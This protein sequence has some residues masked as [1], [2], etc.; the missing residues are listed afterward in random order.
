MKLWMVVVGIMAMCLVGVLFVS[1]GA[2][3]LKTDTPPAVVT[4]A[5]PVASQ[6]NRGVEVMPLEVNE[7]NGMSILDKLH[8][9]YEL[10][11]HGHTPDNIWLRGDEPTE[12]YEAKIRVW[13]GQVRSVM[14]EYAGLEAATTRVAEHFMDFRVC[15]LVQGGAMAFLI[16]R[17]ENPVHYMQEAEGA[18]RVCVIPQ[19]SWDSRMPSKFM[20]DTNTHTAYILA[21][22]VPRK[23]LASTIFHEF[24]HGVLHKIDHLPDYPP[25][26][27]MGVAEEV[28]MHEMQNRILNKASGGKLFELFEAI[29]QRT[30]DK[31]GNNNYLMAAVTREDLLAYDNMLQLEGMG[32]TVAKSAGT[33]FWLGLAFYNIDQSLHHPQRQRNLTKLWF[34]RQIRGWKYDGAE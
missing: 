29:G 9:W 23:L 24:G 32:S 5:V 26:S 1:R 3:S 15:H 21:I 34:Y 18:A 11:L 2:L 10:E 30:G 33:L 16:P 4:Q 31:R 17:G 27:D 13:A 12:Q 28:A 19:Q 7:P 25:Q 22:E 20:Y 8:D 14:E 6:S